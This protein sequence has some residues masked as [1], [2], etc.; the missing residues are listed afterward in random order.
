ML[1]TGQR[2]RSCAT[3]I[4]TD[5]DVICVSL[6]NTGCNDANADFAHEFDTYTGAR[7]AVLQ[8]VNQLGKIFDRVDVVV[9]GRT[10]EPNTWGAIANSCDVLVNLL[11]RQFSAFTRFRALRYFDL[12][13]VRVGQILNRDPEATRSDLFDGR[14]LGVSVGQG[15]ES[16]GI[17]APFAGVAFATEAIHGDSHGFVGFGADR[18]KAHRAGAKSLDDTRGWL[19][20]FDTDCRSGHSLIKIKQTSQRISHLR[21]VVDVVRKTPVGILVSSSRG[22]LYICDSGRVPSV[23]FAFGTPMKLSDVC[24]HR[25]SVGFVDW[26]SKRVTT[27]GLFR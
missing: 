1:D 24:E 9:R 20:V 2:R 15:F 12:Q 23:P 25:R 3:R 16:H 5:E 11:A 7:I 27:K 6:C 19:D 8:I 26:I 14:P 4:A 22:D 21:I 10:D 17:F 18:P 13:F